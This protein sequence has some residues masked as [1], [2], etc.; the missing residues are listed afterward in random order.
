ML[1]LPLNLILA[2]ET[3]WQCN[4]YDFQYDMTAYL[5]VTVDGNA[6]S[7]YSNYEVAAFC[8]EECRGVASVE[9]IPNTEKKSVEPKITPIAPQ[10]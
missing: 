4:I 6:I 3:H 5:D 9:E 8:G 1:L 7:D 2:Q 10:Q